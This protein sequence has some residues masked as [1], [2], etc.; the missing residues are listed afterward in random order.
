MNHERQMPQPRLP[1]RDWIDFEMILKF[2]AI[3]PSWESDVAPLPATTLVAVVV[4]LRAASSNSSANGLIRRRRHYGATTEQLRPTMKGT[5]STWIVLVQHCKSTQFLQSM[6]LSLLID[7]FSIQRWR[8]RNSPINRWPLCDLSSR[9]SIDER[10]QFRWWAWLT[11]C[12]CTY[13]FSCPVPWSH[14]KNKMTIAYS[15]IL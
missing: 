6:E 3:S 13:K 7:S 12:S 4:M 11:M 5:V 2:R 9:L 8:W 14:R 1:R 10:N 15:S